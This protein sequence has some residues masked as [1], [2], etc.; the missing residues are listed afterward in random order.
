M[1]HLVRDTDASPG[2][3]TTSP[4]LGQAQR[5]PLADHEDRTVSR[6]DEE[7]S[8]PRTLC[9]EAGVGESRSRMTILVGTDGS[10][11]RTRAQRRGSDSPSTVVLPIAR[12]RGTR[13][14]RSGLASVARGTTAMT[15]MPRTTAVAPDFSLAPRSPAPLATSMPPGARESH[16]T[17]TRFSLTRRSRVPCGLC[18]SLSNAREILVRI[19]LL[20]ATLE[21]GGLRS[22]HGTLRLSCSPGAGR[23]V[24]SRPR[25]GRTR[26]QWHARAPPGAVARTAESV[27]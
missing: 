21:C 24:P 15:S 23:R 22:C 17:V 20:R 6:Q 7:A 14:L 26:R 3:S 18:R 25:F 12:T 13:V 8:S 27:T 1:R 19:F 10:S 9:L 11:A 2:T 4:Q 5:R 16:K